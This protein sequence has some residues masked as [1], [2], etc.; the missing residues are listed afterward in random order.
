MSKKH[1]REILELCKDYG[2]KRIKLDGLL[3][4]FGDKITTEYTIPKDLGVA[5]EQM[6]T[7]DE[8]LMMSSGIDVDKG[9]EPP[10]E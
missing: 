2:V 6:P 3:V 10:V 4:E 8:F 9:S 7:D 1:L 5:T